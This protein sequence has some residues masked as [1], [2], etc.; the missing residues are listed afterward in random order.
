MGKAR[1][2]TLLSLTALEGGFGEG[3]LPIARPIPSLGG[4]RCTQ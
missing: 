3:D 2:G 4:A 1:V